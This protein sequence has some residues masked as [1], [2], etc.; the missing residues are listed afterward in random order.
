MLVSSFG[1]AQVKGLDAALAAGSGYIAVL[2]SAHGLGRLSTRRRVRRIFKSRPAHVTVLY[3]KRL[4]GSH[5]EKYVCRTGPNGSLAV[6]G[7]ADL[8]AKRFPN[9]NARRQSLEAA[10]R[11]EGPAAGRIVERFLI[12]LSSHSPSGIPPEIEESVVHAVQGGRGVEFN[13]QARVV[14][15]RPTT[16]RVEAVTASTQV[17]EA[18]REMLRRAKHYVYIEDQFLWF[19]TNVESGTFSSLIIQEMADALARDVE[20]VGLTSTPGRDWFAK[21]G[22]VVDLI[23][24][25]GLESLVRLAEQ[26]KSGASLNLHVYVPK[27]GH[28]AT[29]HSKLM[30]VDGQELLIGSANFAERS[31][32][33]DAECSVHLKGQAVES[34]RQRLS[35][36]RFGSTG[37]IGHQASSSDRP[38]APHIARYVS[39]THVRIP[40]LLRRPPLSSMGRGL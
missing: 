40:A 19:G 38:E 5:H 25:D 20:V 28:D 22:K 24:L 21:T 30:I 26:R 11:I 23:R 7:S 9:P 32:S 33:K 29:V 6:V 1:L 27:P 2:A 13:G 31:W 36:K 39:P 15:T 12:D 14:G 37:W 17:G 16:D 34:I 10:L 18:V 35:F 3:P 4:T 8:N